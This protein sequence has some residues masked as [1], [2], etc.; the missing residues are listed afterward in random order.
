METKTSEDKKNIHYTI[1]DWA[2]CG[3]LYLTALGVS[4]WVISNLFETFVTDKSMYSN[5][6]VNMEINRK[7]C[8]WVNCY[9]L[10]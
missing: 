3:A 7:K 5:L 4:I 9:K 6:P 10:P 1:I 2:G 8:V